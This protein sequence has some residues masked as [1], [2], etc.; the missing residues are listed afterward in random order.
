MFGEEMFVDPVVAPGDKMTGLVEQPVWIPPGEWI[1]ADTGKN[2]HGPQTVKRDFRSARCPSTF[3]P[4]PSSPWRRHAVFQSE[5]A[6]SPHPES[7]SLSRWVRPRI[8]RYTKMP[9]TLATISSPGR[10]DRAQR[11]TRRDGELMVKIEPVKGRYPKMLSTRRYEIRL[12]GD[13]PPQSVSVNGKT[14]KY[15]GEAESGVALRR[16]HADDGD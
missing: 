16:Q 4:E 12:P 13:W 11:N 8:T 9:T 1:E 5:A 3:A 6:R 15:T 2:F 14:L 7:L 10:L